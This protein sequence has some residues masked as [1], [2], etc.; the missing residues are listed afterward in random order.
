MKK[1]FK[2]GFTLTILTLLIA[3]NSVNSYASINT[4]KEEGKDKTIVDIAVKDE[5]FTTLVKALQ[6]ADLVDTLK[7]D[8]PF[9][10]FAP[11]DDAF[12]KLGA[13][14]INELLKPENK[15]TLKDI[16]LYHVNGKNLL[17]K[18]VVKLNGKELNMLNGKD[19][20]IEVKNNEVYIDG[21]KIIITDIIA[22]NG[23]IHVIDTVMIP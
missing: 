20:K 15:G 7:D 5:R 17:A 12:K 23:V 18:D 19:A 6:E 11:T 4:K 9:T 3:L 8:G 10:V 16:L 2:K 21:A 1:F 22:K 13:D 14:K